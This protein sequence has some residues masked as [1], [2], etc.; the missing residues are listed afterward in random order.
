MKTITNT[1][2]ISGGNPAAGA[3][4]AA[5]IITGTAAV[6]EAGKT[7]VNLGHDLGEAIYN[8]KHK[9]DNPLGKMHYE[10]KDYTQAY[11]DYKHPPTYGHSHPNNMH[12]NNFHSS[13]GG[14]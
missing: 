3:A 11:L 9:D 8:N 7:F 10:K 2:L 13:F 12:G 14:F 4:A 5:A 1:H 6:I